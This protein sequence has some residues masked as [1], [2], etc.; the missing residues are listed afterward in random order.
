MCV[1][2]RRWA[3]RQDAL[4]H[5]TRRAWYWFAF[6]LFLLEPHEPEVGVH[7]ESGEEGPLQRITEVLR[8]PCSGFIA[9][10]LPPAEGEACNSADDHKDDQR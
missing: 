10:Q 6:L 4:G 8:R 3:R 1:P 2:R 5:L 7:E 9:L